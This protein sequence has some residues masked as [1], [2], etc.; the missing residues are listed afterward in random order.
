MKKISVFILTIIVV[1]S[2]GCKKFLDVNENPNGPEKADPAL[3]L[4]PIQT[5]FALAIQ[6]DARAIGPYTQNFL[7]SATTGT[8]APWDRHGYTVS[9]DFGG[10]IWRAVYWKGGYNLLDLVNYSREQKKWDLLGTGLALQAWGWQN[11]TDYHGP[12]ILKEAFDPT[13]STFNYDEQDTVYAYVPRL[14]K[15]A[16]AELEKTTD[17]VGSAL[18][19]KYDLIYKGDP[20]KWKKFVYGIL[21]INAHHLTKK[22]T[23]QPDS[24]IAYVDKSFTSNDDNAIAPFN[25][26]N[27]IDGNFF[28]P[29]R[30]NLGVYGQSAFI[31]RLTDGT[32]FGGVKDPRQLI[33]LAPSGD[34]VYR[35]LTPGTGQ[36]SAAS[37]LPTGVRSL[38]GTTLGVA[39]PPTGTIGR[40]L[41]QDKANFPLMTY[42]MLQ[43]MKAEAAFIKGDLPLARTAYLNGINAS[44][45]FFRSFSTDPAVLTNFDALK[46]TFLANT[47]VNPATPADLTL[48]QILLQKYVA[49]WG[50]GFVETWTDLRKHDYDPTIF[51]SF[52]LPASY[53]PDNS[54]KP[55][56]RVRPRYNSEYLWNIDALTKIGGFAA[57]YH[58]KKMWIQE[59]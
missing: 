6:F 57:D 41:F 42:S 1:A 35:G 19:K 53:F 11:L 22:A 39:T 51:T 44:L 15:E 36:S 10:E 7:N 28:G 30:A 48:S 14:C 26:T 13:K 46:T 34:G 17:G 25:G 50:Y 47:S 20:V 37:A 3:Y 24:V 45:D 18:Y 59:P 55:A 38:W 40:Y 33:M 16:I 54:N 8:S 58:T 21:A 52:A 31:V 2:T 12:V 56:Y 43:F 49:L 23:Y 29:I 32:V 27:S 4:A 5:S 9:N